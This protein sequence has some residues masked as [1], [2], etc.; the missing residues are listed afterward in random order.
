MTNEQ[1]RSLAIFYCQHVPD[2]NEQIRQE[3]EGKY[4]ST[5]RLF[6]IPCSGRLEPLHLL[7]ALETF[8]DAAYVITCPEGTCR[9]FEGNQRAKKRVKKAQDII[10]DIGLGQERLGII[11]GPINGRKT[12]A[13]IFEE[14]AER[15]ARLRP[16]PVHTKA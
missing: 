8:A 11:I 5:L 13:E 2:S 15:A 12:L 3:L 4:G 16:S 6:P 10:Q 7:K 14:I 9:Y 1:K